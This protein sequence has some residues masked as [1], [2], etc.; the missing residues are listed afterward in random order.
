M[1]TPARAIPRR[2]TTVRRK[3]AVVVAPLTAAGRFVLIHQERIPIR[4]TIWEFPAGQVDE[5]CESGSLKTIVLRELKEET[6]YEL[7]KAGEVKLLG[8]FYSSPGFTDERAFLFLA[9]NV[10]PSVTGHEHQEAEAI[11]DCRE[12]TVCQLRQMIAEGE[13][14]DANTLSLFAQLVA[15]GLL[16]NE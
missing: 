4:Q 9:R 2:W 14:R 15:R 1:S 11:V 8:E 7:A 12:F 5:V 10:Q 3:A 13:I 6:G 16:P